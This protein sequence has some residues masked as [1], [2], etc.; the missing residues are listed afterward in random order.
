MSGGRKR[1]G[2]DCNDDD[3]D[4][5]DS[6]VAMG[7]KR[8]RGELVLV[9]KCWIVREKYERRQRNECYLEG[10]EGIVS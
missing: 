5:D 1:K 6:K 8:E 7:E 9:G 10:L 3:D 2:R 4:D